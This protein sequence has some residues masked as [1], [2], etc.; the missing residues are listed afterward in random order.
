[1]LIAFVIAKLDSGRAANVFPLIIPGG[2]PDTDDP[3]K[4]PTSDKTTVFP[5]LVKVADA[6]TPNDEPGP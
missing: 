5:K 4:T 3:G 2:I 1:M 6:K